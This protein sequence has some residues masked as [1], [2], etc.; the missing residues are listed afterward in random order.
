MDMEK[1]HLNLLE[2]NFNNTPFKQELQLVYDIYSKDYFSISDLSE[3]VCR[4]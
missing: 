1:K 3:L 2:H 4:S